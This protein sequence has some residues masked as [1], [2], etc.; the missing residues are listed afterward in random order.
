MAKGGVL[1][2]KVVG[3]ASTFNKT[4]DGVQGKLS[5]V[6]SGVAKAGKIVALGTA[7]AAAGALALGQEV[8]NTGAKL[9][10]WRQKTSTV[11]EGSAADIR[12]W[13]DKN[14]ETFGVTDDQLAGM[15]ASFGDLLKPMGFTAEQAAG[16]SKDVVGLS[17]ALSEW[18]GGQRTAAEVSDILAKAM[19]G[20]REGLKELGISI[21]E[22][23]VSGRL[24]EK[25]QKDLT[26]S[27]LQQAKA[28]ATQE[29]IFEKSTD[30]Q[31]AYAEGGNKALRA[32]NAIRAGLGELREQIADK[33]LPVALKVGEWFGK[34]IPKA[35]EKMK[36]AI[37]A[38]SD[39]F[40]RVAGVIS[41]FWYTLSSGFTQDE[42]TAVERFALSSRDAL[43]S[44]VRVV[45]TRVIPALIAI[46]RFVK[47]DVVPAL[48]GLGR[49][50]I[51]HKPVLIGLATAIGV[52]LV[53]A[54]TAWAVSAAAAAAA[55]IAAA[56]PVIALGVAIAALA[57]GVI[58][59]YQEWDWF[60]TIVD[61]VA[62][63][64]TDTVWPA[65]QAGALWITDSLI[66]AIGDVISWFGDLIA[67][68]GEVAQAI[69]T[70]VADIVQFF[71]DLP[72]DLA[73]AAG[74]VFGFLWNSFKGTLNRV[75]DA[76]NDFKIP[77][78][79]I[80]GWD[81]PGPGPNV[82][83]FT[84]PEINFKDI[85]R[86]HTG[87]IFHAPTVG[88]EGLALLRDGETVSTSARRGGGVSAMRLDPSD[89]DRLISGIVRALAG[90]HVSVDGQDLGHVVRGEDRM[91]GLRNAL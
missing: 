57:A 66:P 41:E 36:P 7:A 87:G 50:V 78:V 43:G 84:T 23:E 52:G 6:A 34:Q 2:I 15:A 30:A 80:G 38:V 46:G 60:R 85:P 82:P 77:S 55:T 64:L 86:L 33:L 58:Y 35:F 45:R 9:T 32:S 12:A 22:A 54:F 73:D 18:S 61:G 21:T 4:I 31:T 67:K 13:A 49:W 71:R 91:R 68:A 17:G 1:T 27:A 11:F 5:S 48:V 56:A 47:D 65:I 26:G 72:G 29:L 53:A 20:E 42:G 14:N 62:R 24:L 40:E 59:A 76:W 81:I 19:L 16:M 39:L 37:K 8:L 3:D 90:M 83:S 79:K 75:V 89:V 25:G 44:L 88:G 28:L 51:E 74:D 70:T 10:A 63:F 69:G